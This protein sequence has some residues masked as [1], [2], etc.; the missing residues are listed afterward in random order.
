MYFDKDIQI[1]I[2]KNDNKFI[3]FGIM[4]LQH[5]I[6]LIMDLRSKMTKYSLINENNCYSKIEQDNYIGTAIGYEIIF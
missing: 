1:I 2:S 6:I 4:V 5:I 3:Y